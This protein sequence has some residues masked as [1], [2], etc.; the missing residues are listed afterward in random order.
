MTPQQQTKLV[1]LERLADAIE[2]Y[3]RLKKY[4]PVRAKLYEKKMIQLGKRLFEIL[5]NYN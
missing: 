5:L 3:E 1:R 2:Y 4:D